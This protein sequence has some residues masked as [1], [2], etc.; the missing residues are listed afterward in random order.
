[1]IVISSKL[2]DW[3]MKVG[4]KTNKKQLK[5]TVGLHGSLSCD[6]KIFTE[7][8]HNCED[9]TIPEVILDYRHNT[10]SVVTFDRGGQKRTTFVKFDE[11]D[12]LFVTRIKID[13]TH[14]VIRNIKISEKETESLII[15]GD[16]EVN[17]NDN[18]TRK[19][20][21]TPFR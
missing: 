7:N 5:V 8:K 11:Q 19:R 10:S 6:F 12:I 4:S 3:G 20:L 14:H 21:L 2:V 15:E 1:M 17:F 9:L 18:A 13:V 16:L